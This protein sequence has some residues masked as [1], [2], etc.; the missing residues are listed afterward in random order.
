VAQC[1]V[2]PRLAVTPPLLVGATSSAGF[3]MAANQVTAL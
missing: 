1:S 3:S 2:T